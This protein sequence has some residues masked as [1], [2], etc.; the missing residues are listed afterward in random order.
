MPINFESALGIHDRALAV[1]SQRAAVLANNIVNADTPGF[2][3]RDINFRDAL[4]SAQQLSVQRMTTTHGRHIS[5]AVNA[6]FGG[7]LMY[8]VPLQPSLDGNTVDLQIEQAEYAKNALGFQA[9]F[10]FLNSKINGL[11][12]AIRGE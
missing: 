2:K 4:S 11:R 10:T 1:R 9:S 6:G 7:A 8:R 3:A 5:A 12:S